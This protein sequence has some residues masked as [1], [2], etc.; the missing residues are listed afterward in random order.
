[1]VLAVFRK[2]LLVVFV[3][4]DLQESLTEDTVAESL[5]CEDVALGTS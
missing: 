1:M 3:A 2:D 4:A 5:C